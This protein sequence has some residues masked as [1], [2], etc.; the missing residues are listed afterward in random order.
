[1]K[2]IITLLTALF[3]VSNVYGQTAKEYLNR[4]VAKTKLDDLT[5]AIADYN[6]AINLNPNDAD[7]YC[8]RGYAKLRLRD[9][10]GARSDFNMAINLNP[11]LALAYCGRGLAKIMLGQKDS[12]CLD[13]SKAGELGIA[14][15]Y[16]NIKVL[17]N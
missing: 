11:N 5:G 16:E 8:G 4:G 10:R 1:M 2:K 13:L 14:E 15:A 7:A 12:G 17:C 3:L 6:K 9:Y